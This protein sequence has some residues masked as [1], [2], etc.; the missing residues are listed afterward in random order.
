MIYLE[1]LI[2]IV[3]GYNLQFCELGIKLINPKKPVVL[4]AG[5]KFWRRTYQPIM[6]RAG[7]LQIWLS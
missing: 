3:V 5:T 6:L 7:A 2:W 4:L 1:T